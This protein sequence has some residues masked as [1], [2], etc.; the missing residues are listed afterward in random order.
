MSPYV[1]IEVTLTR[2]E[3]RPQDT[4]MLHGTPC[5]MAQSLTFT[6]QPLHQN[7]S[8]SCYSKITLTTAH[9]LTKSINIKS[10]V[11]FVQFTSH[12]QKLQIQ[13]TQIP[14]YENFIKLFYCI[15]RGKKSTIL[16]R[17]QAMNAL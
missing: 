1:L 6:Q 13:N 15:P 12:V 5:S 2:R 3:K 11:S 17:L 9:E 4:W 8:H 10:T 16:L 14:V 7:N